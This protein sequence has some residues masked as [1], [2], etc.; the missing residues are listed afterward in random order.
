MTI[1]QRPHASW[2]VHVILGCAVLLAVAF[3][4]KATLPYLL[5]DPSALARYASRRLWILVHVV[6]A[7][8]ALLTG[9][10]QLW[11]G[12][13]GRTT[14]GHR[15]LGR[16]YVASVGV[17]AAAAFYLSTHTELGWVTGAGLTGLGIAWVVTTTLGVVAIGRGL[18]D[19][20]R[21]WMIRSYVVTFAFVTF[22]ALF[23]AL[24]AADIGT[25]PEQLAACSWFCWAVPLI[26]TE[27]VLQGRKIFSP[28]PIS[29][30]R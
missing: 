9:P 14:R 21:E 12:A 20:H 29:S 25:L 27:A 18:V 23:L 16:V 2:R 11:L 4:G 8:V 30:G 1:S 13:R 26:V 5:Q 3:L 7:T 17:A 19:Q 10:V 15:R 28:L 24:Q 6:A 22:R